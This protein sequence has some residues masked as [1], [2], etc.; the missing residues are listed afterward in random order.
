MSSKTGGE[1]FVA[2][3]K[4]ALENSMHTILDRLEKSKIQAQAASYE[5]L[6]PW[7]LAPAMLLLLLEAVVRVALLRRFP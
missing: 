2:T 6:F 1:S 5:E 3:D 4:A 7:L